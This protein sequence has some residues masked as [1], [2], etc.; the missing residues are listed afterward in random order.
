MH[1]GFKGGA[2][3]VIGQVSTFTKP[4]VEVQGEINIRLTVDAAAVAQIATVDGVKSISKY[5]QAGMTTIV[6]RSILHADDSLNQIPNSLKNELTGAGQTITVADSGFDKGNLKDVHEAFQ[7]RVKELIP[8]PNYKLTNDR[9]GHGTH[10]AGCA[11]A[12]GTSALGDVKGTAPGAN[13]IV[14][15]LWKDKQ[16]P[17]PLRMDAGSLLDRLQEAVGKNSF[18]YNIS[19]TVADAQGYTASAMD[20]D[21]AVFKNPELLVCV[22]AGN[23]GRDPR[24]LRIADTSMAKN[25]ITVGSSLTYRRVNDDKYAPNGSPGDMNNVHDSST[26]GP[27]AN[28][29][30]LKPDVVAPGIAILSAA[31]RDPAFQK[32]FLNNTQTRA[33]DEFGPT[34]DNNY[35]FC[36]GTS[37][38][39]PLV[40][41]CAAQLR[42]ALA[43]WRNHQ[44]PSA[45]LIKALLIH[46]VTDLSTTVPAGRYGANA[47]APA[48][49]GVQGHGRVNV[50]GSLPPILAPYKGTSDGFLEAF[51][52]PEDPPNGQPITNHPVTVRFRTPRTA[53][54]AD[55]IT[56]KVTM[57]YSDWPGE[58]IQTYLM[59]QAFA[60]NPDGSLGAALTA[61]PA[62]EDNVQKLVIPNRGQDQPII[63]RTTSPRL[64]GRRR[65]PFAL[66]WSSARSA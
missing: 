18:V 32:R 35:W 53:N 39:S 19:F 60:E 23:A 30:R 46:G 5:Q 20:I 16:D 8:M 52:E 49:N 7:D 17:E 57:V 38:A 9:N 25:A 1:K 55:T 51:V 48:P 41:G 63:L 62:N 66:V 29:T 47:I 59:V 15:C 44:R 58:V 27:A 6:A 12:R 13:L 56:A 40:A 64:L 14:Q 26:Q 3:A 11:V 24:G 61:V 4:T 34:N 54:P 43:K 37:M 21:I 36:S 31:S 50:E 65:H 22:G 45:A 28:T 2:G 42:E 10:V 33:L